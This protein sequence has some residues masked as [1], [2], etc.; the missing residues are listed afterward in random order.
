MSG[1]K[2]PSA[3]R[4]QGEAADKALAEL[5]NPTGEGADQ[6]VNEGETATDTTPDPVQ[7]VTPQE[8]APEAIPASG[9]DDGNDELVIDWKAEAS[10]LKAER[11]KA[12]AQLHSLQGKYNAEVPRLSGEIRDLKAKIE[13]QQAAPDP[14]Q[15]SE[16][17]AELREMYGDEIVDR[18]IT[19]ERRAEAAVEAAKQEL[20]PSLDK[21]SQFEQSAAQDAEDAM[22]A[23]IGKA[24]ADWEKCNDMAS[25]K[26]FLGEVDANSGLVRQQIVDM[27]IQRLDPQPIIRQLSAFKRRVKRGNQA[28][29]TQ[30]VPGDSGRTEAAPQGDSQIYLQSDVDKFFAQIAAL[31]ARGPLSDDQVRLEQTYSRAMFEGRTR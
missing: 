27:A 1:F 11:D 8:A 26:S 14:A 28:L 9:E 24:H 30:V 31:K 15:A 10:A 19:S 3:V 22:F 17:E 16:G 13:Q 29:E 7:E 25:F 4:K 12:V 18:L 20:K 2:L 23:E 21:I 5:Q 6:F